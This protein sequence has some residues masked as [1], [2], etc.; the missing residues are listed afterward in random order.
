MI[1][2]LTRHFGSSER[3]SPSF[4]KE[5]YFGLEDVALKNEPLAS[6]F[7]GIHIITLLVAF[8][9]GCRA[10]KTLSILLVLLRRQI[11]ILDT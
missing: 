2:Y 10:E 8:V 1:R 3:H 6:E 7:I 4:R 9:V 5:S 11:L